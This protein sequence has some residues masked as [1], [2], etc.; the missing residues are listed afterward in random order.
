MV[1][2]IDGCGKKKL[3]FG[4]CSCHYRRF[5]LYGDPNVVKHVQFHGLTLRERLEARTVRSQLCWEWTGTRDKRGYG[6]LTVGNKPILAHRISWEV[7]KGKIPDGA[8]VLHRCD[9]PC[10]VRPSHLFLGDHDAN[11][12]DKMAKKRHRFGTSHG[13]D[14]GCSKLTEFQVL[15]IRGRKG[16]SI[17]IAADYGVSGRTV[18]EIRN[19]ESWRHLP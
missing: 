4:L 5:K 15:E 19:R 17:K 12:A 16:S 1:C 2:K 18:R 6:R 13:E 11:M 14:H 3:A 7:Y 10:C 9:N 8:Q